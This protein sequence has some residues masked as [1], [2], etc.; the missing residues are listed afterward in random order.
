[1]G[2][3]SGSGSVWELEG[4]GVRVTKL[5]N[6]CPTRTESRR[7][8]GEGMRVQTGPRPLLSFCG[9]GPLLWGRDIRVVGGASKM[10]RSCGGSGIDEDRFVRARN[11][12]GVRRWAWLYAKGGALRL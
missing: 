11:G 6:C 1:M 7:G 12:G 5:Q 10:K 3:Q 4:V 2:E 9:V 8:E